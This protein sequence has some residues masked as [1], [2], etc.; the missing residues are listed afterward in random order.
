MW[1]LYTD[2]E[3]V[4]TDIH[5]TASNIYNTTRHNNLNSY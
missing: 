2:V 4:D 5:V 3:E 1:G